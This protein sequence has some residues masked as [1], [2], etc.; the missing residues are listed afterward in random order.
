MDRDDAIMMKRR[1]DNEESRRRAEDDVVWDV[2]YCYVGEWSQAGW[3]TGRTQKEST[4][5]EFA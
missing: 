3:Q 2:F 1:R 5:Q 4:S